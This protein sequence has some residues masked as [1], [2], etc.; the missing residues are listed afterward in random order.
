MQSSLNTPSNFAKLR[1][2]LV[3][4]A[5]IFFRGEFTGSTSGL[6]LRQ[7]DLRPA[8]G[9]RRDPAVEISVFPIVGSE[10]KSPY[11]E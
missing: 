5:S 7:L 1:I 2:V 10:M 6:D 11:T 3:T 4:S 9:L 8:G